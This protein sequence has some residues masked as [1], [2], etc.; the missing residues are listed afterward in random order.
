MKTEKI[1]IG[2][3]VICTSLIAAQTGAKKATVRIKTVETINGTG[4]R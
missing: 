1:I 4:N 2:A 3:F